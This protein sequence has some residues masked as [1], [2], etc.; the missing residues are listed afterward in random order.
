MKTEKKSGEKFT[1]RYNVESAT[2]YKASHDTKARRIPGPN[3]PLFDP[4]AP[5]TFDPLRVAEIDA[6]GKMSTPIEVWTDPDEGILWILD[7]R[8]RFLDVQEVNRR[9][10]ADGRELV[11]AYL[12][13]FAG[14]E[15]AAIARVRIK[16]YHRRSPTPSGQA[17]DL[18]ALRRA[19]W[20]YQECANKLH[21]ETTD[22]EQWAR[23]LLPLAYCIPEVRA[24]IDAGELVRG[25]AKKFGGTKLDGSAALGRKEQLALLDRMRADASGTSTI[26]PVSAKLRGRVRDQLASNDSLK[27]LN[28][29]VA[30]VVSATISRIEGETSALDSWPSVASL[31]EQALKPQKRGPKPSVSD[32]G[33]ADDDDL[34][35]LAA[36]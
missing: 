24:A 26:R 6:E 14:D 3:H 2:I 33:D 15:K 9:R 8:G 36:Y 4:T 32:D 10:A 30:A 25:A 19:G 16:N 18:L 31:V 34:E 11:K 1:S 12:V 29:I 17:L 28:R 13:P 23:K 7:G 21:V 22:S 20:S 27:G 35:R 5:T